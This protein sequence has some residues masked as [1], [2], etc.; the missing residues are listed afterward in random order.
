LPPLPIDSDSID[1]L[2]LFVG[3]KVAEFDG[4]PAYLRIGR[5][6]LL[7]GSERLVTPLE[8]ANTRQ[9]FQGVHGLWSNGT[10]DV[11][12]FWTQYVKLNATGWAW[13]DPNQNFSGA[14]L[15]YHP[16]KKSNWDLYWLWLVNDNFT[17]I[18]GITQDPTNVHTLGT[19]YVGDKNG[20]LWDFE[21]MLQLGDRGPQHILAGAATAGLGYSLPKA[22]MQPTFWAYYDYASGS[23][24]PG[25][26]TYSTFNQLYG[27]GHYYLGFMD[28]IGRENIRDLNFQTYLYPTNWISLNVQYHILSLDRGRDALYS[29][30]GTPSRVS[31][32]GTAGRDVGDEL[33]FIVNF[34]LGPHSD[35]LTGWSQL[36]AGDF[37]RK[38]A[39]TPAGKF[40]PE[41]F[42][43]MYNI[44]W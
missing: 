22:F 38:T 18:M 1:F 40:D 2:N 12:L 35:I 21:P 23:A 9:T 13:A 16:D 17:R 29:A 41:L 15:T 32:N 31:H 6:E 19:R 28:L 7:F 3:L 43:F 25:V 10:W 24:N 37:L 42:Y 8:W 11:D 20:F 33:T 39:T 5:Q 36:Y 44:R 27:F 14:W 34:H 30:L 26:G 4:K